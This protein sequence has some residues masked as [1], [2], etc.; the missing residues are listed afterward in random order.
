MKTTKCVGRPRKFDHS[1][2]L[3][4]AVAV[5]GEKGYQGASLIELSKAMHMN[6]P[7]MY[8]AFGD[9]EALFVAAIE[10]YVAND[11]CAPLSAFEKED[12]ITAAIRAFFV[13]IANHSTESKSRGCL[14]SSTVATSVG[15]VTA[16]ESLLQKAIIQTE[17]RFVKRFEAAK[18]AGQLSQSF[19]ST[20]QARLL[21]DIRQGYMFRARAGL[22]AKKIL[23]DV[24]V[25]VHLVLYEY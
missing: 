5:F 16:A 10:H 8:S 18:S 4:A 1:T 25:H 3:D 20:Q 19:P 22:S 13:T 11:G 2:A 14:M 21:F 23:L 17:K 6:T 24:E 9:K 15:S 12:D 7:S